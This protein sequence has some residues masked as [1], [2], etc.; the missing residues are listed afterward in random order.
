MPQQ[1][2]YL[3]FDEHPSVFLVFIYGT[4]STNTGVFV[5][6]VITVPPV[7]SSSKSLIGMKRLHRNV[8]QK[9]SWSG[10]DGEA[11]GSMQLGELGGANILY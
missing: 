3:F 9:F 10:E 8:R 6:A 4:C 11:R 5:G 2:E 1:T 7:K